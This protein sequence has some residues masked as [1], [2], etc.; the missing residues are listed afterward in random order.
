MTRWG[1]SYFVSKLA[2]CS[3]YQTAMPAANYN[4]VLDG[5]NDKLNAGEIHIGKPELREGQRLVVIDEGTR[6]A[7]E[8]G[9]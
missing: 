3:Y 5:V 6:Y 9:K 7:I 8:E 2:A 1:T 4:E